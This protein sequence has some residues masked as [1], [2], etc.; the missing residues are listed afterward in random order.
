M[1]MMMCL[2]WSLSVPGLSLSDEKKAASLAGT[3]VPYLNIPEVSISQRHHEA[4]KRYAAVSYHRA[5]VLVPRERLANEDT[6]VSI[7]DPIPDMEHD[8]AAVW[9]LINLP[10]FEKLATRRPS[11]DWRF[12]KL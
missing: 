11:D 8:K 4:T 12:S 5:F 9:D 1:K 2:P 7:R 10:P 6:T 3:V